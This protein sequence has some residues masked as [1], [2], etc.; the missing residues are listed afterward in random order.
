L[1]IS[2]DSWT[3][4]AMEKALRPRSNREVVSFML[5]KVP[6]TNNKSTEVFGVC[7]NVRATTVKSRNLL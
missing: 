7:Y 6:V 1:A 3:G 5:R 2:A 4:E